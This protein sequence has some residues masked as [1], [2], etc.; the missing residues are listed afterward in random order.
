MGKGR[1]SKFRLTIRVCKYCGCI[2]LKF[3]DSIQFCNYKK[4]KRKNRCIFCKNAKRLQ[5]FRYK[6]RIGIGYIP[7]SRKE[8]N[9]VIKRIE[10]IEFEKLV[11]NPG[12]LL[13]KI[14]IKKEIKSPKDELKEYWD[15]L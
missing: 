9:E 7:F 1:K 3:I 12:K 2:I 11:N 10:D 8:L 4:L 6:H 13:K 14:K 15:S 5:I